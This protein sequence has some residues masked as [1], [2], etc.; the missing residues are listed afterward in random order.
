M[1]IIFGELLGP[2]LEFD[3]LLSPSEDLDSITQEGRGAGAV[4]VVVCCEAGVRDI[5]VREAVMS[6]GAVLA[7]EET[8]PLL[9]QESRSLGQLSRRVM[10][11]SC[12]LAP[13]MT[14]YTLTLRQG[15]DLA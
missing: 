7:P 13:L 2:A 6:L 5:H 8:Q 4:L 15:K 14:L 3:R 10:G 11:V 1:S 12:S 9:V